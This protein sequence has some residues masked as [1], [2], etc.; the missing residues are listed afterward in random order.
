MPFLSPGTGH[1][2]AQLGPLSQGGGNSALV[3]EEDESFSSFPQSSEPGAWGFACFFLQM[4]V[5]LS[6]WFPGVFRGACRLA[7][8]YQESCPLPV[9]EREPGPLSTEITKKQFIIRIEKSSIGAKW[10]A[11]PVASFQITLRTCSREAGFSAQSYILSE[12][13]TLKKW[14]LYFSNDSKKNRPACTHPVSTALAPGKGILPS[15]KD[16][17]WNPRRKGI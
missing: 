17:H 12:Q 4:C 13:R 14:G 5:C 10:T 16:Q 8:R 6:V 11:S 7:R 3:K 15:K 9:F 1:R 2:S